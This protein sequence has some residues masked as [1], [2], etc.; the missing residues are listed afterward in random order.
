[1]TRKK[2]YG[3]DLHGVAFVMSEKMRVPMTE[4]DRKVMGPA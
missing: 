4:G 3:F 2:E 1:M